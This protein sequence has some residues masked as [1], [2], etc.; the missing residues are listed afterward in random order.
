VPA[1][2]TRYI[3]ARLHKMAAPSGHA[4]ERTWALDLRQAG[5]TAER[6]ERAESNG[7]ERLA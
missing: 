7:A 6:A 5:S 1:A 4:R 2:Q 3:V